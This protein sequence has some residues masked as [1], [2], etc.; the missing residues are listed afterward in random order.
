MKYSPNVLKVRNFLIAYAPK[1]LV[2]LIVKLKGG[3]TVFAPKFVK[4]Q[5][6]EK[7]VL[8]AVIAYNKN[9]AYCIPWS[10]SYKGPAQKIF[11]GLQYE[12]ETFEYIKNL[13]LD[14]DIIHAGAYFGDSIPAL[15]KGISSEQKIWSFEPSSEN[16]RAAQITIQLNGLSN[17]HLFRNAIGEKN[18]TKKV[19]TKNPDTGKALGATS[20]IVSSDDSSAEETI[21]VVTLDSAIPADRKISLMHIDVEGYEISALSGAKELIIR[22]KPIIIIESGVKNE[23]RYREF[24]ESIGYEYKEGVER[25]DYEAGYRNS[26]YIAKS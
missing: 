6:D 3:G 20:R 1:P 12:N 2:A 14:G 15:A 22:N 9:G 19:L 24:M 16:F 18:E 5:S 25:R 8:S 21:E 10:S 23:D 11:R 7:K 13:H 17:V 4:P 26:V